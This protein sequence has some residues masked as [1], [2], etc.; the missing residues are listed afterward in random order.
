MDIPL[1]IY[2]KRKQAA[3]A[4]LLRQATGKLLPAV[5]GAA[6]VLSELQVPDVWQM[7]ASELPEFFFITS[8]ALFSQWQ[9]DKISLKL[10]KAK[11]M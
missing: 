8:F 1:N 7:F 2:R 6:A 3:A 11:Q 10:F 4:L 5:G 9:I